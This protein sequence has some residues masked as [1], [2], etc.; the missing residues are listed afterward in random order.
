MFC[1]SAG[2][3]S[4]LSTVG[5]WAA[6]SWNLNFVISEW[7]ILCICLSLR[8]RGQNQSRKKPLNLY[9]NAESGPRL[10][11]WRS[12]FQTSKK[13]LWEIFIWD[14]DHWVGVGG[15]LKVNF[16]D[17]FPVPTAFFGA[18]CL[19]LG[20]SVMGGKSKWSFADA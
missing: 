19:R 13:W 6:L 7:I 3:Q 5:A 15:N 14:T 20:N 4:Q 10:I 11:S 12:E 8:S 16:R 18:E 2:P 9:L 17:L 1:R